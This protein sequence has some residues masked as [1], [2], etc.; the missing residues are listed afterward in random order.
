MAAQQAVKEAGLLG[1]L[2][3]GLRCNPI[4]GVADRRLRPPGARWW[5]GGAQ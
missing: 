5:A 4:S 3:I 1:L 2:S